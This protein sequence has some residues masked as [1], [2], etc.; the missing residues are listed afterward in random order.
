MDK[1]DNKMIIDVHVHLLKRREAYPGVFLNQLYRIWE[2]KFGKEGLEERKAS[3]DGRVEP[4]IND[5]DEAGVDKS[6]VSSV[7]LGI[8]CGEEP[9][10]SIWENNEYVAESQRRYPD[11]IIG[12]VGVDPLR[13]DAIELLEKGVTEWGL[14]GV[15]VF[16]TM[17]KVTDEKIQP[18]MEKVNELELPVLFHQG[19]DPIPFLMQ[20]GN[21]VDLNALTLRYPN[22]KMIAAHVARGFDDLLTEI[23]TYS[24]GRMVTDISQYQH[25]FLNTRWHFIMKMRYIIDRIP[26]SVLMGSDWPFVKAPPLPTHKEWFDIIR[27][28]KIPEPVLQLGIGIKD[29]SQEEKDLILGENA[30]RFLG[31]G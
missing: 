29:F 22:M 3:L 4:L 20:Y 13:K 6:V 18:F 12:F 8:M 14:R 2:D 26:G 10:V 25:L 30:K 24:G 21:P 7:D 9:E 27:N 17:Y 23:I 16:P 1:K 19:M 5:M 28:L 11:R 15:K 31:I